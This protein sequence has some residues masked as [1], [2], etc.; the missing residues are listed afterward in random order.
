MGKRLFKVIIKY[1]AGKHIYLA[2]AYSQKQ[3]RKI[4]LRL[5]KRDYD[6]RFS[7]VVNSDID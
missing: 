1:Y 4:I 5:V 3:A 7:K 6:F 2:E